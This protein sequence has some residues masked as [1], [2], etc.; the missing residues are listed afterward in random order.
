MNVFAVKQANQAVEEPVSYRVKARNRA[1]FGVVN[2][3][4]DRHVCR[5]VK[6]GFDELAHASQV[7][8]IAPPE[9]PLFDN[10]PLCDQSEVVDV[11][12]IDFK[13]T[14][15]WFGKCV[16]IEGEF[17]LEVAGRNDQNFVSV[18][19]KSGRGHK[20]VDLALAMT[21]SWDGRPNIDDSRVKRADAID[22]DSYRTKFFGH[23][24]SNKCFSRKVLRG[25]GGTLN[26]AIGRL[27]YF[28]GSL[29]VFIP[30]R[31]EK[32][33]VLSSLPAKKQEAC[34]WR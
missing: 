4:G 10:V 14:P 21:R 6:E 30:T 19:S 8:E 26:K 5:I 12:S 18:S 32:D 24:H 7:Q 13:T 16:R 29:A 33:L 1:W 3:R 9:T 15:S 2:A 34:P 31:E 28:E 11:A 25:E 27:G 17:P 22:A 23:W 20:Q